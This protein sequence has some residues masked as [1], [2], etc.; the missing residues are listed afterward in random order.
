[1]LI[2]GVLQ[3]LIRVWQAGSLLCQLEE[4]HIVVGPFHSWFCSVGPTYSAT[5]SQ[6]YD[7]FDLGPKWS[8]IQRWITRV[9][10]WKQLSEIA[11]VLVACALDLWKRINW[12][13]NHFEETL[14]DLADELQGEPAHKFHPNR[15]NDD[16]LLM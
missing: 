2:K 11:C 5:H 16:F 8:G 14:L 15:K 9:R 3:V 13:R 7:S 12:T 1:M 10:S 6:N 4:T